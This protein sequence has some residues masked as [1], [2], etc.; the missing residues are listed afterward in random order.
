MRLWKR[1]RCNTALSRLCLDERER[2]SRGKG[3]SRLEFCGRVGLQFVAFFLVDDHVSSQR[4]NA[5]M[6]KRIR[7]FTDEDLAQHSTPSSC[8]ITRNGKVY[9]VTSFMPD[10]PGGDD[11][12][13]KYAGQDVGEVMKDP[14]EHEHS[15]AAYDMLDE[16]LVGRVGVGE[17]IVSDGSC[18][19]A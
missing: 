17:N 6:S 16:Y 14:E 5:I 13:L 11:L 12:I 15:E 3:R 4:V 9:D 10:H 2:V 7:I 19:C 1:S 18:Q 8:W